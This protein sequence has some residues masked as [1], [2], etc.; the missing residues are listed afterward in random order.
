MAERPK[1]ILGV[2]LLHWFAAGTALLALFT[3]FFITNTSW[4]GIGFFSRDQLY[5]WHK[6]AGIVVL[7]LM[8]L[9]ALVRVFSF[10]RYKA[11]PKLSLFQKLILGFHLMIFISLISV[12]VIGWMANSAGRYSDDIFLL[13]LLPEIVS[14]RDVKLS[15]EL[16]TTHKWAASVFWKLLVLHLAGVLFHLAVLRDDTFRR[17]WFSLKRTKSK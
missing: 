4:N 8:L 9:W 12:A 16:Y 11:G 1:I 7:P 14:E 6:S 13:S 5:L 15:F 3:G 17:M 2:R 10:A